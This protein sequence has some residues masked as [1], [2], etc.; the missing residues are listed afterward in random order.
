ML[1]IGSVRLIVMCGFLLFSTYG[2]YAA[3][4]VDINSAT[5]DQLKTLPGMTEGY[6]MMVVGAR[7]FQSKE[8][9]IERKILP[10]ET[11]DQMKDQIM[12]KG[13]SAAPSKPT[14]NPQMERLPSQSAGSVQGSNEV[15]DTN[16]TPSSSRVCILEERTK[17]RV[18]GELSK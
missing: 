2:V 7:P 11:Y 5:P 13:A 18:C 14:P 1:R 15:A 16:P 10:Q 12:V 8:D 9:L 6:V 4:L 3:A 17:E